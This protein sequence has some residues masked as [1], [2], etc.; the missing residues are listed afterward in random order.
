M[1]LLRCFFWLLC[2][3]KFCFSK[4]EAIDSGLYVVLQLADYVSVMYTI[5]LISFSFDF[6]AV[7]VG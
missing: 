6:Y 2:Q 1:L 3:L 4:I 7:C 5:C